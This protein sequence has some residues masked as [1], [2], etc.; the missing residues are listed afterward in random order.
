M[1]R[2]AF[3]RK[4]GTHV[5]KVDFSKVHGLSEVYGLFMNLGVKGMLEGSDLE[6]VY[7]VFLSL[8]GFVDRASGYVQPAPMK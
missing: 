8:S 6:T 5:V 7:M 3:Q 4:S 1:L 2:S